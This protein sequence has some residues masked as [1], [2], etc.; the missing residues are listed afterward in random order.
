MGA[1]SY[2]E[3]YVVGMNWLRAAVVGLGGVKNA[4]FG[5]FLKKTPVLYA[6]T[7]HPRSMWID[8]GVA[9]T[10]LAA[11]QKQP[12]RSGELPYL[13]TARMPLGQQKSAQYQLRQALPGPKTEH[14][15]R[16][17]HPRTPLLIADQIVKDGKGEEIRKSYCTLLP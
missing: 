7:R 17:K 10:I 9:N 14:S 16:L 4:F 6:M 8:M 11:H 13:V 12:W 3:D 15:A 1:S 2:Q 5:N